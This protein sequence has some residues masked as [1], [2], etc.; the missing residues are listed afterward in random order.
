MAYAEITGLPAIT[1]LMAMIGPLLIYTLLGSSRHLSAGPESTTAL[2]TATAVAPIMAGLPPERR[3][4]AT[5]LLALMVAAVAFAGWALRLGFIA[6]LLR[7]PVLVGY[8]AG[9][10]VL[11]IVSQL[12]KITGL[13]VEGDTTVAQ[14]V[15]A[16]EQPATSWN[17]S[18]PSWTTRASS[19][20]SPVC[21]TNCG[22]NW[23]APGSS[24]L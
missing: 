3:G 4:D 17:G 12:G 8:L 5:A 7:K 18:A 6:R 24:L 23:T 22:S 20:A 19:S 10:C 21:N 16:A 1:G 15:S 9:I 14:V 11:M 2:R 13:N